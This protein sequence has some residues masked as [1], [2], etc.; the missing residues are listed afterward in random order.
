MS[1]QE[2]ARALATVPEIE[3]TERL[4]DEA[5]KRLREHPRGTAPD[6]ARN[7]VIDA[8]VRTFQADGSWPAD[9]G[10]RAAKAYT[11]ALEWE[12][13]RIARD[14]AKTS[15]ELLA[16]DTRQAYSADAL[17]YLG[18]RLDEVLSDAREAAETL[19][20][21]RTADAAIKAGG[22]V[23]EAWGH[24]QG[25]TDDLTNIR[26][27]QWELLLPRLRPG[28]SV[29]MFDE[30]RR[31]LR[32]WKRDG[33]GEVKGSLDDVPAFVRAATDSGRYS[34]AVLLWLAGVGTA[35]VPTSFEDLQDDATAGTLPDAFEGAD[36]L[37]HS[38]RVTPQ[39]TPQPAKVFPHSSA[40]HLDH[41]QPAPAQPKANATVGDPKPLVYRY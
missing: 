19:G 36:W 30:E 15:T 39:P 29:G 22:A 1:N 10:K 11:T 14:R 8:T 40:P 23:V 3:R 13:E 12:A 4:L 24:L 17:A 37:D 32:G 9:L 41:S 21:A 2:L 20:D 33:F 25:L 5:K 34:E 27:A 28:D 35:H 18:T 7:E 26:S 16:Y 38:P 31:K 6:A